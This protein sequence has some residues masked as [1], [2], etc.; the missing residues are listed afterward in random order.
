MRAVGLV[1]EYNPFHYGHAYHVAQSKQVTGEDVV[2][3]VMSGPFLQRGEPAIVNKWDRTKQALHQGVDIVMEL[4]YAFATQKAEIFAG[5]AVDI[6]SAMGVNSLCFGSEE[7]SIEPFLKAVSQRQEHQ[8]AFDQLVQQGMKHGWSYPHAASVAQKE[9]LAEEEEYLLEK[10]NNILGY[11]YVERALHHHPHI[12][13]HTIKRQAAGYHEETFK[14]EKIASATAIRRASQTEGLQAIEAYVPA[15]TYD[16]LSHRLE[17]DGFFCNWEVF[18]PAL[19]YQLLA[20]TTE[21]LRGIY[22][23]EE[24]VEVRL[25]EAAKEAN[26]FA[27]FMKTVKTKRYTWTRLQRMCTHILTQTSK[28]EMR[29]VTEPRALR[30]LGMT[31]TGQRY[32]QNK[33]KELPLPLLA[34]VRRD[35]EPLVQLDIRAQR[36]YESA[37]LFHPQALRKPDYQDEFKRVPIRLTGEPGTK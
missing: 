10:P 35:D 23:V 26:T 4:P 19:R 27:Q 16:S 8:Q 20:Q 18:W 6:L 17:K 33:K 25:Q 14:S 9:L 21:K 12:H 28:E 3:A 13:L 36:V 30:L 34:N 32:I 11:H 15:T 24:G 37:L 2:I 7:G 22:E 31:E 5:G 1:V 29:E